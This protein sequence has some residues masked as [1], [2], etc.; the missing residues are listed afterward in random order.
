MDGGRVS[1]RLAL[2]LGWAAMV[3]A[4][5]W[6]LTGCGGGEEGLEAP[7]IRFVNATV[8]FAPA[9]FRVDGIVGP[10]GVPAGGGVTV[11]G[12][13]REGTRSIGVGPAGQAAAL[14]QNFTFAKGSSATVLALAGASGNEELHVL[15]EREPRAGSGRF[16]LRVLNATNV[17]GF[18][19]YVQTNPP[20]LGGGHPPIR[21]SGYKTL[22]PFNDL[23]SGTWRIYVTRPGDTDVL[24]RSREVSFGS[25]TVG[26][27]AIVPVPGSTN[28]NLVA[29]PEG[30]DAQRLSHQP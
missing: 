29:L 27:V 22:T 15:D 1:R 18:D 23:P 12:T 25:S 16:K 11:Y 9:D 4:G 17:S 7:I 13:V 26:T 30:S 19:V 6:G 5:A 21:V 14:T 3:I 8:D 28:F 24:F 20:S 2:R 10:A